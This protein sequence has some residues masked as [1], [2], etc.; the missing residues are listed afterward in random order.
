M[1]SNAD[2]LAKLRCSA[3]RCAETSDAPR[4]FCKVVGTHSEPS[5][6]IVVDIAAIYSYFVMFIESAIELRDTAARRAADFHG[7]GSR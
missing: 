6:V 3:R 7:S 4:S 2:G 5:S 1:P